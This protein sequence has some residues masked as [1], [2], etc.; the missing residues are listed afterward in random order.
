MSTNEE[1]HFNREASAPGGTLKR[2]SSSWLGVAM[3]ALTAICGLVA[4]SVQSAGAATGGGHRSAT[5]QAIGAH[6]SGPV[7]FSVRLDR[8]AVMDRGDGSVLVELVLR[9]DDV[10]PGAVLRTPTDLVVVL[11][12]SGS[13]EGQAIAHALASTQ[14]LIDRLGP[15]DRFALVSYSSGA[16][17]EIPLSN[18]VGPARAAWAQHVDSIFAGGGTDMSS[19]LDLAHQLVGDGIRTGRTARV[20]LIS[21]GHANQGDATPQGL[22]SR[23]RRAVPSEYVLSAVGVGDGFDEIL[24]TSPANAGT[25]NFYY[26]SDPSTLSSIFGEEL[27]AARETV[28]RSVAIEMIPGDGVTVVEA[29]GY[30]IDQTGGLVTVR[31]G[32]LFAGQERRIWLTLAIDESRRRNAEED[33]ALG[34][35][36]VTFRT[37]QGD[38]HRVTLDETPTVAVVH[39]HTDFIA[40][41]NAPAYVEQLRSEGLGM[42]RQKVARAVASGKR[43]LAAHYISEFEQTNMAELRSLGYAHPESDV[44]I[45]AA[46]ELKDEVEKALSPSAPAAAKNRLGKKLSEEALDGRR[47]GAKR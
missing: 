44:A 7:D 40:A 29:A 30:P 2:P 35:L 33:I 16:R 5:T 18:A 17:V 43:D 22:Q 25:G 1:S 26:V 45:A 31:P 28:A 9:G 41:R 42:L 21:D 10:A 13:M 32:S 37:T 6:G 34:S 8:E 20:I 38:S 27:L 19:G 47:Q 23:A 24:M 14:A 3:L 36:A 4:H 11:D 12:R 15:D 46:H 39:D